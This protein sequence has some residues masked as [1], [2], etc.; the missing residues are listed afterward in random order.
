MRNAAANQKCHAVLVSGDVREA[1]FE[2]VPDLPEVTAQ[3]LRG[4]QEKGS[5]TLEQ[6][7][8]HEKTVKQFAA[9]WA[10]RKNGLTPS[11]ASERQNRSMVGVASCT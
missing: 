5:A 11:G 2:G 9:F 4:F 3:S 10:K 6:R 7:K 1:R 8:S